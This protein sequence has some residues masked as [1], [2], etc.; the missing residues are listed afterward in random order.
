M[1]SHPSYSPDIAPSPFHLFRSL[2]NSLNGIKNFNSSID[3]KIH[4]E[5]FLAEKPERF[6]KDGI[7]KLHERWGGVV[8]ENDIYII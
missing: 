8:E 3:I 5:K 1:L 6:C 2:Q 4:I 7:F